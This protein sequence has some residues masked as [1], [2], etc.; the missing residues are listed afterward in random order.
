MNIIEIIETAWAIPF[1]LL[2][3]VIIPTA[4][5]WGPP[6]LVIVFIKLWRRFR[7]TAENEYD[8]ESVK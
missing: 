3:W 4:P 5:F 7:R 1:M 6:V 2:S 8:S